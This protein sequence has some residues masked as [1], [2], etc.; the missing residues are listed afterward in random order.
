MK[1]IY[2]TETGICIVHPTGELSIE[3]VFEK[4]VPAE[5]KHTAYIVSDEVIPSDRTF[6]DSW[7]HKIDN[8]THSVVENVDKAKEIHKE[9]LRAEREIKFKDLDSQQMIA[10][11]KGSDQTEINKEKER[12]CDITKLVDVCETIEDIKKVNINSEV[13]NV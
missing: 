4:D 12:L 6:R 9:R 7:E 10:I 11:R 2:T 1:I 3:Q 8:D 5:Y 13:K